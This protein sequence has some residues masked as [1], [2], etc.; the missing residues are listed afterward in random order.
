MYPRGA[1]P[2][3]DIVQRNIQIGDIHKT[4]H[5]RQTGPRRDTGGVANDR[6]IQK[7]KVKK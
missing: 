6:I 3:A 4:I 7:E 2:E 1:I 5:G